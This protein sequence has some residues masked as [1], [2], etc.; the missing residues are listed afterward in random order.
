MNTIDTLRESIDLIDT[1]IIELLS[2]R[3]SVVEK[4]GEIKKQNNL[5]ALDPVR[6]QEMLSSRIEQ[7]KRCGISSEY[8]EK[9][10][11]LIHNESLSVQNG[12]V[13]KFN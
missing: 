8:I 4:I 3:M 1:Q 6:K 12:I 5:P 10:F 9:I 7:G 2:S 11:E 13:D